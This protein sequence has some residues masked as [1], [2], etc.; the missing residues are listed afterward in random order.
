M[1]GKQIHGFAIKK[2][3]NEEIYLCN[4]LIDMYSKCGSLNCARRVFNNHSFRKDSISWS[5]MEGRGNGKRIGKQ[6]WRGKKNFSNWSISRTFS[7]F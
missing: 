6:K 7:V 1:G 4:A 5:L 2:E 3:L